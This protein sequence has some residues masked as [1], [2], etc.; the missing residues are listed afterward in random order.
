MKAYHIET[1][2]EIEG[3]AVREQD[4]PRPGSHE[5][6]VRIRATS[7]NRRDLMILKGSYP[8]PTRP[9]VI[10]L[11]DGAGEVVA[12]GS[13][14]S[15]VAVGDRITSTY[16]V[17]WQDG[18]LTAALASEQY[19]CS[20]DGM[21]AEYALLEAESVVHIPPHLTWEEAAT[22]PCAALT[23]WSALNGPRPVS[24]GE[25]VL[26]VGSGGVALFALQFAKLFGTQT[27]VATSSEAK[28]ERLK[29]LGGRSCY[30][31]CFT[32]LGPGGL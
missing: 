24:P 14:V 17:G 26:I 32:G 22:L 11:S 23:A 20:L 25:T 12:V 21:L 19:G 1:L 27:I 29:E 2:G 10:P 5:V 6:L 7:L 28:A 18:R 3:L 16:F 15:G 9:D 31:A 4:E 30:H 8:V 13:E